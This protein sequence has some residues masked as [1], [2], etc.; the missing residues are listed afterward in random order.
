MNQL[1]MQRRCPRPTA[2]GPASATCG[3]VCVGGG[4]TVNVSTT[5][6]LLSSNLQ[7]GHKSG[8]L[9]APRPL[10]AGFLGSTLGFHWVNYINPAPL[11]APPRPSAPP[12]SIICGLICSG[13]TAASSPGTHCSSKCQRQPRITRISH[14]LNL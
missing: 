7:R 5:I 14:H 2:Y 9:P 12:S 8:Q 11:R 13:S 3:S 10:E 4:N 6:P 1:R